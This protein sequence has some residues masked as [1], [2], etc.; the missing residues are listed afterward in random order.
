MVLP[1]DPSTDPPT[2]PLGAVQQDEV[3][4]CFF[5]WVG[6]SGTDA[7]AT[8]AEREAGKSSV[9]L[10]ELKAFRRVT[11][12]PAGSPEPLKVEFTVSVAS[13][14]LMRADGSMGLLRGR[15]KARPAS[16]RILGYFSRS[17]PTLE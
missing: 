9:P 1:Q 16:T 6:S 13:L 11:L 5:G 2:P 10:H 4:E 15:W 14:R 12:P 17:L 7:D 3:I 8:A